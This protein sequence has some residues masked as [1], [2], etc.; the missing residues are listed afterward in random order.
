M[1]NRWRPYSFLAIFRAKPF[2]RIIPQH[3][4]NLVNSTPTY[5]PMR[6]EQSVPKRRHIKFRRWGITQKKS[7]KLYLYS[8]SLTAK[9]LPVSPAV[10]HIHKESYKNVSSFLLVLSRSCFPQIFLQSTS[11]FKNSLSFTTFTNSFQ[12]F[13][14]PF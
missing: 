13:Q 6:M 4:S 10:S 12:L 8:L 14:K 2:S 9:C 1:E 3:L 5:L 7:Y 11:R